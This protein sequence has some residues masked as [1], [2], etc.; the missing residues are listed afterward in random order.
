MRPSEGRM[1]MSF[2]ASSS[3]SSVQSVSSV[4]SVSSV[5]SVPSASSLV[6]G[7]DTGG[8]GF[9]DRQRRRKAASSP[10]SASFASLAVDG[11][12]VPVGYG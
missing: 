6:K 4:L 11:I 1:E 12:V 3:A 2:V 8:Y 10:L 9:G 7:R 5:S